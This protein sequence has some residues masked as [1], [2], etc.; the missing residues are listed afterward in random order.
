MLKV[1]DT[2]EQ[3]FNSAIT[4]VT[5][6]DATNKE[7]RMMLLYITKMVGVVNVPSES[8]E[9]VLLDYV[10]SSLSKFTLDEFKLAFKLYCDG[11]LDTDR[12]HFQKISSLY[13]GRIMESY[14]R[15]RYRF[16]NKGTEET[17]TKP[18]PEE[19]EK[20]MKEGCIRLFERYK[21]TKEII[22][23]GC[24]HYKY[25]RRNKFIKLTDDDIE[26]IQ[27]QALGVLRIRES[28]KGRDGMREIKDSLKNFNP[29]SEENKLRLLDICMEIALKEY[30]DEM[31][32][33]E[34][35]MDKVLNPEL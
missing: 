23:F 29:D 5:I 27:D 35:T 11:Q 21:R 9:I 31:L 12:E 33:N 6:K 28:E 14:V 34:I 16:T 2:N 4:S 17:T 20:N 3:L 15:W 7:I 10:H 8:E 19:H 26:R 22:D 25:L 32:E 24:I 13:L 30:F 1:G 18:T